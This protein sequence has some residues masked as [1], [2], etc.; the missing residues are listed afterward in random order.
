MLEIY[1]D[2]L[3]DLLAKNPT[4]SSTLDIRVQGKFVSVPG[5]TQ[6]EVRTEDD[7]INVMDMNTRP[8]TTQTHTPTLLI[9]SPCLYFLLLSDGAEVTHLAMPRRRT[10]CQ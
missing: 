1:N 5:L 7:I 4:A 2:T 6:V 3:N 8:A 9:F 10:S